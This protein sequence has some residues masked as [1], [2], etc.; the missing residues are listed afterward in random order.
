MMISDHGSIVHPNFY[1][2]ETPKNLTIEDEDSDHT[3][4]GYLNRIFKL[5]CHVIRGI[6]KGTLAWIV[7]NETLVEK[8]TSSL[9]YQVEPRQEN[10]LKEYTCRARNNFSNHSLKHTVRLFVYSKYL[11]LSSTTLVSFR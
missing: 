4:Y 6:P 1:S 2:S 3:V 9:V 7:N 5:R 10:H 8:A 11:F